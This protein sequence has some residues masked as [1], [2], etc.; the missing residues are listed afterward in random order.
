MLGHLLETLLQPSC[1]C[2]V[3][4]HQ[5]IGQC[6]PPLLSGWSD[7]VMWLHTT[8]HWKSD[9][10]LCWDI[11]VLVWCEHWTINPK[12]LRETSKP[13]QPIGDC[14]CYCQVQPVHHWAKFEMCSVYWVS[15]H[16]LTPLAM[17]SLKL[18]L[19]L[20]SLSWTCWQGC[21]EF[22]TTAF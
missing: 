13:T 5:G 8:Q 12:A 1:H 10:A 21:F 22:C 9:P 19:V 4:R 3:K 18:L 16:T 6:S 14:V 2:S 7:Q 15:M 17:A 20:W 11:D